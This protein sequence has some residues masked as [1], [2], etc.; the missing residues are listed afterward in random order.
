MFLSDHK[1]ANLTKKHSYSSWRTKTKFDQ[2]NEN[3]FKKGTCLY[4]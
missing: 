4:V 3:G 2:C 1:C